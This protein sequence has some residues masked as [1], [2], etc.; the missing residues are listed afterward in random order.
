MAVAILEAVVTGKV[1]EEGSAT[2][3]LLGSVS[4]IVL[5]LERE[6]RTVCLT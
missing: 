4:V 3:E 5:P 2:L 6:R 1:G